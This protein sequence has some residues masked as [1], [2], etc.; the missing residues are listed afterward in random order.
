[1]RKLIRQPY[2][3]FEPIPK[4]NS[5]IASGATPIGSTGRASDKRQFQERIRQKEEEE[6][7][8]YD[9]LQVPVHSLGGLLASGAL[10]VHSMIMDQFDDK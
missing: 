4:K 1:M 9:R 6:I 5:A 2:L 7:G 10:V 3:Y 8:A